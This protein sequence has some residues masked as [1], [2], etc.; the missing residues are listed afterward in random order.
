M[1]N[2][3]LKCEGA[4]TMMEVIVY[5]VY[6]LIIISVAYLNGIFNLG[7]LGYLSVFLI[8]L[9][10]IGL[11]ELI[12]LDWFPNSQKMPDRTD[13]ELE[14]YCQKRISNLS[15][16][17]FSLKRFLIVI[18]FIGLSFSLSKTVTPESQNFPFLNK[19]NNFMTDSWGSGI[20]ILFVIILSRIDVYIL[21]DYDPE[22]TDKDN[23]YLRR[24]KEANWTILWVWII[25]I[26]L[27]VLRKT[28]YS[29]Y[30]GVTLPSASNIAEGVNEQVSA[31]MGS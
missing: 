9:G 31:Q 16:H 29:G 10:Y 7:P 18:C 28:L 17:F 13:E 12:S 3:V 21:K 30:D 27:F 19:I 8:I 5:I 6:S 14:E 1:G 25:C 23:K 2:V 22:D 20:F 26:F 4:Q 24:I 15:N 11:P